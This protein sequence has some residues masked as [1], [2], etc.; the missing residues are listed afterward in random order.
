MTFFL[1][2]S[3]SFFLENTIVLMMAKGTLYL[4]GELLPLTPGED[5][6]T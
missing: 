1:F 3:K 2:S 6:D 4:G 5:E